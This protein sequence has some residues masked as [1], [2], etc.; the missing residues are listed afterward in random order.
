L[1][2]Y[3]SNLDNR[4]AASLLADYMIE[5]IGYEDISYTTEFN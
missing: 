3:V 4:Q 1:S 5:K 2:D